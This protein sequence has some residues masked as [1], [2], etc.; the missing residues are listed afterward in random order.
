MKEGTGTI[1]VYFMPGMAAGPDIFEH[2]RLPEESFEM[3]FLQWKLPEN[4]ESLENYARRMAAEVKHDHSVLIGVSLGGVIVQEMNKFLSLKRLIII[5]SVKTRFE[6]PRRM[7]YARI[8]G[9]Y[10]LFPTSM[11]KYIE[12]FD[13]LPL[14][15]FVK[16][17]LKLYKRYMAVKD[18]TYLDWAFKKMI[19][20]DRETPIEGIVHIH[21]KKDIVLPIKYIKDCIVVPEGTHIMIINRYRWFNRNL[22]ELICKG[23]LAE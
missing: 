11:V 8:T 20:W 6:L 2:I 1:H 17:R 5:S 19:F 4:G 15:N 16:K 21:G 18:K 9:A 22:P 12:K 10:R 13:G 23:K 7:R 3:H 14:G